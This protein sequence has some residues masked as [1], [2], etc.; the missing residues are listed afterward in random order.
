MILD[1]GMPEMDGYAVAGVRSDPRFATT[2]LIALS[3]TDSPMSPADATSARLAPVKPVGRVLMRRWAERFN[4]LA[5][6]N[7][8]DRHARCNFVLKLLAPGSRMP[9]TGALREG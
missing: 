4:A 2:R 7:K 5:H 6:G 3:V 9:N 8:S 1:L